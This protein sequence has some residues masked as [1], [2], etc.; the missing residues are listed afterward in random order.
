MSIYGVKGSD[1]RVTLI[2]T[3]TRN[4]LF[5]VFYSLERSGMAQCKKVGLNPFPGLQYKSS[6]NTEKWRNCS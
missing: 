4:S 6:E 1:Y 5:S 2:N 3:F